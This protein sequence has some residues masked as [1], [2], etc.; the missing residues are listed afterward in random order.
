MRTRRLGWLALLVLLA[1]CAAPAPPRDTPPPLLATKQADRPVLAVLAAGDASIDAFD[2]AIDY[3][4]D[5]L[6]ARGTENHLLT[7]RRHRGADMEAS[8]KSALLAR[9]QAVRPAANGECFVYLTSH[10]NPNGFYLAA[11]G[12]LLK[13]DEL[14]RAL[15]AGCGQVP[16]VI[17]V[18]ACYSGIFAQA[19][20]NRPNRI[21]LTA[22]RPDR[23]SFGCG[24][25]FTYT[26][27]DECL[28]GALPN[29]PDWHVVYDRARG[30]VDFRERQVE[31]TPSEP[32]AAFGADVDGL[33]TPWASFKPD[34]A[35]AL[36][37]APAPI[38]Y[39]PALVPISLD[40]RDRQADQLAQYA[41]SPAPKALAVTP[42]G[43]IS[44]VR[45]DS[46]GKRTEADVA[47]L[48]V[49][50]CE[51]LT[52]GACILFARD[53]RIAELMPSGEP[54]FHP[55]L[56]ER[57][58]RLKSATVPFIRDDQR[59]EID[60]YLALPGPK[61]LALSPGHTEL[62]VGGGATME[63][64]RQDALDRCAAG[65]QE[66]LIYAENDGIVLGWG[67]N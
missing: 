44:M 37:F 1:A 2:D 19:P 43:L 33:A 39:K 21:V 34:S 65:K 42:G 20:M 66:C 52:G 11:S 55:L 53:D 48:A 40:E 9:L 61:A 57:S 7:A 12:E 6:P 50:R 60:A 25:G 5:V 24:A 15:S 54:P 13:P 27:F 63:D 64:A 26:Y 28:I 3:L 35:V 49:Q 56:L 17:V 51:W 10:G 16:T 18:S 62:G 22:A 38:S 29:A 41:A 32:Q 23:T 30:C 36:R 47:R 67:N 31:A 45:P 8:T 46:T 58:G 4:S 59:P 14:D